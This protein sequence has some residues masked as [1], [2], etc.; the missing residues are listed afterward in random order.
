VVGAA[1]EYTGH[2]LILFEDRSYRWFS[3]KRFAWDGTGDDTAVVAALIGHWRYRDH[4]AS[5]DSHEQ[6]AGDIHGPYRVA[7]I[8]PA[9]FVPVDPD[10]AAALVEEFCGLF[11]YPPR[12]E[13]R[14]QIA[15][16]ILSWLDRSSCYRL[17]DLPDA[18]HEWGW[19]LTEFRELV[20]ISREAS[21]V[22]SV[23]M[24]ID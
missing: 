7:A 21:E 13:V 1:L 20:A 3:V 11:G 2:T 15:A 9:E 23:V 19:V 8:T 16:S 10:E 14:D 4:Y 18:I 5:K 17:R 22:L 12:P 24:A 6:D